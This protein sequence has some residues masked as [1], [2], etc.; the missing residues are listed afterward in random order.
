MQDKKRRCCLKTTP[1]DKW[2]SRLDLNQYSWNYEFPASPLSYRSITGTDDGTRTRRTL[3]L[4]QVCKPIP[5][6]PHYW[7]PQQESNLRIPFRRG[8]YFPLYYGGITGAS[9]GTRT[10]RISLLRRTRLPI[11]SPRLYLR[12]FQVYA[13]P[14]GSF[15]S[16][17]ESTPILPTW[18]GFSPTIVT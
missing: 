15:P 17:T 16:S 7:H 13:S 4:S 5:S 3:I 8:L 14:L 2:Y 12:I 9:G 10:H 11:T 18:L 6:H 1:S